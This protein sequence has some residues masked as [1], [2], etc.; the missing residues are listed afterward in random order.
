[1]TAAKRTEFEVLFDWIAAFFTVHVFYLDSPLGIFNQEDFRLPPRLNALIIP[2]KKSDRKKIID[3]LCQSEKIFSMTITEN[4]T[5]DNVDLIVSGRLD[6]TTAPQLESRL[7]E[8]AKGMKTM[9]IDLKDVEYISSA[10]LRVVLV[11]H[12]LM[13]GF[14]GRLAVRNPSPFCKQVFNATGMDSILTI[15]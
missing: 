8:A 7:K 3:F 11:A 13:A 6:T 10:G 5:A 4:K 9:I 12:K 14:G 2:H 15:I 1:M